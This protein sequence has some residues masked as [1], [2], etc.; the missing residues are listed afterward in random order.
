[1]SVTLRKRKNADGS[2]SLRLDIFYNGKRT[3]ETLKHLKLNKPS[4]VKD[5]ED[6]KELLQKAEAIRLVRTVELEGNNYNMDSDSGK[7]TIITIWMQTYIDG[8]GKKDKRNM[9][10]VLNRFTDFLK[11]ENKT[12]LTF[13]NLTALLIEDFID[14]L[15]RK[16]TGEGAKSYY[17]RFK[18]MLKNAYRK[19]FMKDNI[20][21]YVERKVKGK[22]KKKD[23][24]TMDELKILSATPTES[25]EVRKAFL[26]SCVTGLR[27]CDIKPLK[28]KSIDIN[29]RQMNLSQSKTDEDLSTPLNDT[30][31]KLLGKAGPPNEN[32]FILPS[33]NGANK[34]IKAWVKRAEINKAITWHNARHSFGTNLI[35]NDVDV[36]TASKLLGHTS[37][38]QTQ[39]YVKAAAEMKQKATDK[40]NIDL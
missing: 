17:N 13:G 10:G 40:I 32:V 25:S 37:M 16:S 7:K 28:W 2:T 31:I 34:T 14:Y 24:L 35:F 5:R 36:L 20:L 26:F 8:Y 23:T 4:N 11:K 19:K 1:M 12:D 6:N 33:A 18:K 29:S 38:E 27:W 30:A 3:I 21:D 15:E 39:R 9:Q 22:A